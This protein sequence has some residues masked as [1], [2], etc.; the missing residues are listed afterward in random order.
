[1]NTSSICSLTTAS[2]SRSGAMPPAQPPERLVARADLRRR[3]GV[4]LDS[5]RRRIRWCCSAMLASVRK[6]ENA[7]ATGSASSTGICS[8]SRV[9][10]SKSASLPPRALFAR[11]RTRSTRSGRSPGSPAGAAFRPAARRAGGRR[12]AGLWAA[13]GALDGSLT[14]CGLRVAGWGTVGRGFSRAIR[15]VPGAWCR[16]LGAVPGAECRVRDVGG[17]EAPPSC[18]HDVRWPGLHANVRRPG[19][20]TNVRRAGLQSRQRAPHPAPGTRHRTQHQAPSTRH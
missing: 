20:H 8:S 5:R 19:L 9:S 16:V 17:A 1:M 4:A 14:D 12:L 7:R 13:R 11:A 18:F 6:C 10:V 15:G 3:V 2:C